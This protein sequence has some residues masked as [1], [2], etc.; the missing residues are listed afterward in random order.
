MSEKPNAL[1]EAEKRWGNPRQYINH[2]DELRMFA[3]HELRRNLREYKFKFPTINLNNEH[4]IKISGKKTFSD[5]FNRAI[6]LNNTIHISGIEDEKLFMEIYISLIEKRANELSTKDG[7]LFKSLLQPQD[8]RYNAR[9]NVVDNILEWNFGMKTGYYW[10]E[11][12]KY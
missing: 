11:T 3:I 12:Y 1:V 5:T 8:T 10:V 4:V 2:N 7:T 9:A 6:G